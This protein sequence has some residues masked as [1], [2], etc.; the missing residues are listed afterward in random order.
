MRPRHLVVAGVM[1]AALLIVAAPAEGHELV[2]KALLEYLETNPDATP[3]ELQEFAAQESPLFA[4]KFKNAE[5]LLRIVRNQKTTFFD[6]ARNFLTLGVEHIL[7]GPDHILFVLA[8]LLA[9]RTYRDILRLTGTFTLAHSITL[10]L[11]GLDILRLTSSIVEPVIAFSIGYVALSTTLFSESRFHLLA[12]EKIAAVFFFGLFHGLGFAGLLR[13]LSIP[14]E[15]FISSLLSFNLGI[16]I[17][18]LIIVA[19][20]M[21]VIL[22]VRHTPWYPRAIKAAGLVLGVIGISWGAYRIIT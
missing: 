9:F 20:A 13:D 19:A 1:L 21:P 6:N 3:Q 2:P 15:N 11:A 7:S 14:R 4:A 18:Q 8:L 22:A 10:V 17:G 5:E 12:K 16:E